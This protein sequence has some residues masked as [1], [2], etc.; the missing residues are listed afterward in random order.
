MCRAFTWMNG[1]ACTEGKAGAAQSWPAGAQGSAGGHA[2]VCPLARPAAKPANFEGAPCLQGERH[3]VDLS[4]APAALCLQ[5]AP[6]R[7]LLHAAE[8]PPAQHLTPRPANNKAA[9]RMRSI[10]R[11]LVPLAT[12]TGSGLGLL[13]ASAASP[14]Q[15][16][17]L[18]CSPARPPA[19]PPHLSR[20]VDAIGWVL[21][22]WVQN[23]ATP[24]SVERSNPGPS[25]SCMQQSKWQHARP[26]REAL[27]GVLVSPGLPWA[28]LAVKTSHIW[29]AATI[30]E[31]APFWRPFLERAEKNAPFFYSQVLETALHAPQRMQTPAPTAQNPHRS[32]LYCAPP[33][34]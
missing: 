5:H 6:A 20:R 17:C 10:N 22:W 1:S 27:V 21:K 23:S 12:A 13:L 32:L 25:S 30:C 15:L 28:G 33:S 9:R 16:C 2:W 11:L 24:V 34:A 7:G 4:F 14:E 8:P 29:H 31:D 26:C 18:K 3:T 19:R